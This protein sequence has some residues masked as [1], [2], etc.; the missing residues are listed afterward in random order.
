M[1]TLDQRLHNDTFHLGDL[2]L[3]R[4]LLMND[5]R[6]PWLIL[7]PRTADISEVFEL[8]ATQ[9][10]QLWAET[11]QV[12]NALKTEFNADKMNLATLGNVVK[13]LHM[14][15]VARYATD[16]AWPTPVWGNGTA[17]PYTPE[18]LAS[19]QQRVAA[20]FAQTKFTWEPAH[21]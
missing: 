6:F 16:A 17:Q 19:I 8:S 21:D 9:Q 3:C 18:Q 7:V 15:V 4:V 1:F 5:S 10:A 11:T 2:P 12:A 20:A 13:Q 14:H